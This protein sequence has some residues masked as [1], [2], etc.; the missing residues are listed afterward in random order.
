MNFETKVRVYRA[1]RRAG[2]GPTLERFL[3][4]NQHD[5]EL[6]AFVALHEEIVSGTTGSR[7]RRQCRAR[8]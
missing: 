7:L 4:R 5:K 6:S 3:R 1:L 8:P 2:G